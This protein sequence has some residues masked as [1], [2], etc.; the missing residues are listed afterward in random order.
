MEGFETERT[1]WTYDIGPLTPS[2]A[3]YWDSRW[4]VT[5]IE[6]SFSSDL[7]HFNRDTYTFLGFLGDMGGLYDAL[8]FIGY[9]MINK[10]SILIYTLYSFE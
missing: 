4:K 6:M 1:F 3:V 9:F 8:A 10:V 7:A 5:G 2:A